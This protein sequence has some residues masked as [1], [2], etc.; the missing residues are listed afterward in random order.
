MHE[1][2][3]RVEQRYEELNRLLADPGIATDQK[4]L[5]DLL[6]RLAPAAPT[7]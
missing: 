2:L 3:G 5:R 7:N 1:K 6:D 4:R